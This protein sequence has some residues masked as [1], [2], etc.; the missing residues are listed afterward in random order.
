MAVDKVQTGLR[1]DLITWGKLSSLAERESRS[2]NN[3]VEVII[4]QYL[5][6]YEA[7]NGEIPPAP[8]PDK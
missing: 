6:D 5:S 2:L 1:V 3:L 4:K 7:R 8:Y